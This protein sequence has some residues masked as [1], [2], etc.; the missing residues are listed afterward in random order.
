[1][2]PARVRIWADA[3]A[4]GLVTEAERVPGGLTN[5]IWRLTLAHDGP[6]I[7]RWVD[8]ELWGAEG[9]RHVS[10]EALGCDV[11]AGAGLP[12]PRLLASD[13]D[14]VHTGG[15]ANLTTFLPGRV[16]LDRLA[17][18][19]VADLARVAIRVHRTPVEVDR[20]PPRFQLWTPEVL[21]TPPWATRPDLWERAIE[22]LA[23][24]EPASP[25]GLIHRDFHP[26]NT[27]WVG[28]SVTGLIDWAET[29]WGPADLDV[30]HAC[31]NFALLHTTEHAADFR[32]AYLDLGGRLDP[33]PTAQRYWQVGD[34]LGF[35]PDPD[36]V[37]SALT[38]DRP[39]LTLGRVR[40]RLEDL[41]ELT[42]AG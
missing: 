39:D 10:L 8:P 18:P 16:R 4:P 34:I 36:P 30:A 40:R 38:R 19:A 35:L 23:G 12:T 5:T 11:V 9:H 7:L 28:D 1:M 2:L 17:G 13:P 21:S 3:V 37:V 14:G 41:L 20:R 31:S 25:F 22:V 26:G 27:L 15:Y 33:D 29:S 24:P 32:R 6:V 42:L